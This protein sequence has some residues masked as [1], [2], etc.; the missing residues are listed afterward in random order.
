MHSKFAALAAFLFV[1]CS[2][3]QAQSAGGSDFLVKRQA[4]QALA[5]FALGDRR[6]TVASEDKLSTTY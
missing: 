1:A 4:L 2:A 6:L 5:H 3:A